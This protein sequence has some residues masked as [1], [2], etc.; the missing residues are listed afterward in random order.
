MSS[1]I[2]VVVSDVS[3]VSF[4]T[5]LLVNDTKYSSVVLSNMINSSEGALCA[6]HTV[7]LGQYDVEN[8]VVRRERALNN[9]IRLCQE[10]E[11]MDIATCGD[12]IDVLHLL[13]LSNYWDVPAATESCVEYIANYIKDMD[14]HQMRDF[15]EVENDLTQEQQQEFQSMTDTEQKIP[16][17]LENLESI[18]EDLERRN[19]KYVVSK[20]GYIYITSS[21]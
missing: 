8:D 1:T 10:R 21:E 12:H 15:M 16:Y 9:L 3:S 20:N 2:T 18:L 14:V 17:T 13:L 4:P 6:D 11:N 19:V 7:Q 5:E